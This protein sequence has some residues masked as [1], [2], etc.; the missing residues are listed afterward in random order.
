MCL[1]YGTNSTNP[2]NSTTN[3]AT[4]K[5]TLVRASTGALSTSTGLPRGNA[6]IV[7]TAVNAELFERRY[8]D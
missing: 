3:N 6:R 4:N 5:D 7:G 8:I 1:L 2:E